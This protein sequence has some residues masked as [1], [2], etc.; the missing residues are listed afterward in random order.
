MTSRRNS[1]ASL[2]R[3]NNA[4]ISQVGALLPP[5]LITT[6]SQVPDNKAHP[7]ESK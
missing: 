4:V 2:V 7:L 3:S 1:T 5:K 6:L